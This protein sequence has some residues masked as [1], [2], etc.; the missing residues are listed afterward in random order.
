MTEAQLQSA[1]VECAQLLGWRCAHFRPAQTAKG[2]RTA[3]SA[4]GAGYPD[5]TLVR[6]GFLIFAELKS[7]KGRVSA[8]QQRWLDELTAVSFQEDRVLTYL[9][10]TQQWSDGS[11]ERVLKETGQPRARKAA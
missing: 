9:W 4:D 8:E 6:N 11:I 2:W 7:A 5:L 10:T 1:I 3:V